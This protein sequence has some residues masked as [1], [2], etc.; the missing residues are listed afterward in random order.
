VKP[1]AVVVRSVWVALMAGFSYLGIAEN[2][3]NAW[4]THDSFTT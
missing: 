4:L 2:H 1:E 3:L